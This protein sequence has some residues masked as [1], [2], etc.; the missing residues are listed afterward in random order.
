MLKYFKFLVALLFFGVVVTFIYF[1]LGGG[2][3]LK[4]EII[5]KDVTIYGQPF[6]GKYNDPKI[7][8]LFADAK[9][10][11]ISHPDESL[12]IVNYISTHPDSVKQFIGFVSDKKYN[13]PNIEMKEVT[14]V[15]TEIKAHNL[16]MPK[17]EE[18][19]NN[20]AKFANNNRLQLD[21][22]SIELYHE[23]RNLEIIFPC[24]AN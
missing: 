12:V 6:K 20:A 10:Q 19:R 14:F 7:G 17:P 21:S 18:V 11:V 8:T 1:Q 23:E 24:K 9:N 3:S 5:T 13:L 16:V 2:K 15:T 22:F 4:F